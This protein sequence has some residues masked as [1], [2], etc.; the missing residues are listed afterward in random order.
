MSFFMNT[1][2]VSDPFVEV[3]LVNTSRSWYIKI[4]KTEVITD[5]LD[6]IWN[7]HFIEEI[8]D[9]ADEML[10]KIWDK[11]FASNEM[12]GDIKIP[13]APLIAGQIVNGTFPISL[14]S[15]FELNAAGIPTLTIRVEFQAGHK[16]ENILEELQ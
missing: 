14:A 4:L 11:D 8:C 10:F 5:N 7:A 3:F 13:T 9:F 15:N 12:I 6:P 2:D 16:V 1:K